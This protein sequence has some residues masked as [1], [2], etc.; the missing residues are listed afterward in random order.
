MNRFQRW[1][2]WLATV[3]A[4]PVGRP[5][6]GVN[7]PLSG[8]LLTPIDKPW[9]EQFQELADAR[10]AWRRSPLARRE[11]RVEMDRSGFLRSSTRLVDP[12]LN[13]KM[14]TKQP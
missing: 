5:N 10:E 9:G 7:R 3:T 8:A 11:P 2:A 6:D 13:D 12:A 14:A 1:V 4:V